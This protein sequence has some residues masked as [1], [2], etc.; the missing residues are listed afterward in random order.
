MTLLKV[1]SGSDV[2]VT[3]TMA[4]DSGPIDLTDRGINV[5]GVA[6][7]L[8][9]RVSATITDA[10]AGVLEVQVEGTNPI[11]VGTYGF[12]IQITSTGDSIGLPMFNLRVM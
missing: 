10:T 9:G 8:A 11:A 3:L 1:T 12:R 5:F 4:N 2:R 6:P 7:Q